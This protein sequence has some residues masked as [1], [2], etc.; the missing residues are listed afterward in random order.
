[1]KAFFQAIGIHP[2]AA[3]IPLARKRLLFFGL[4]AVAAFVTG[5]VAVSP[6]RA[7]WL[8]RNGGYYYMA[9]LFAGFIACATKVARPR[10]VVWRQ[11]IRRPGWT[12]AVLLLAVAFTL[13][14]DSY[15]HKILFDEY[16]LQATGFHLHATKEV[17]TVVR[18]YDLAGTWLPIDT[19]LD[20]RPYF[21]TFLLSLVHDLTGYRV[22]NVF[23]LNS[24]LTAFFY[25]LTYWFARALAGRAAG[26]LVVALLAT[27]PLLGQN[28]TSA[29]MEIHNLMMLVLVMVLALLYLRAPDADRL[30][31]FC[32][33]TVLLAQSRYESAIFVAPAAIVVV[34]GWVRARTVLLPWVAIVT[35]L[36]L[37]PYAW[38]NRVLSATPLLWQLGEGQTSRFA[39]SYFPINLLGAFRFFFNFTNAVANSWYLSVLGFAGFGWVMWTLART[40][41][42]WNSLRPPAQVALAFG[43]GVAGNFVMVQFYYWAR[44][45]DVVTSRFALP[46]SLILALL[47]GILVARLDLRW[48]AVRAAWLGLLV[49]LLVT[50]LP[51]LAYRLYTAQ[52]V[53]MKEVE[54]ESDFVRARPK[55][56]R[57]IISNKSTIPWLLAEI[58]ALIIGVAR[59]RGDQI[60]YHLEQGT[61]HE[62]IVTQTLRPTSAMGDYGVDPADLLPENFRLE[63]LVEKRF[64]GRMERVSR[65]VSVGPNIPAADQATSAAPKPVASTSAAPPSS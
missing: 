26:L 51:S 43:L 11:W 30:S 47:A 62:I 28:A 55:E 54:W 45:D 50:D 38:H 34:A 46:S 18:A 57:L 49:F 40:S 31:L 6:H 63:T 65:L 7:E 36:L 48:P 4:S 24:L 35:P 33:G 37:I 23:I 14:S 27:M 9:G 59:Q 56:P 32:L 1:M 42:T 2:G 60:R 19:F 58:P 22:A 52:N 20:K 29:G 61:F 13:W 12:G 64:G 44:F 5:F 25:G 41:R 15:H 3:S 10:A 16:V 17:G 8:I 21:F 39:L 53:V